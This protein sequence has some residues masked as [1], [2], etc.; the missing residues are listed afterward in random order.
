YPAIDAAH[1]GDVRELWCDVV[2][3][4]Q[5]CGIDVALCLL[6]IVLGGAQRRIDRGERR[7]IRT[8]AARLGEPAARAGEVLGTQGTASLIEQAC[9]IAAVRALRQRIIRGLLCE[10]RQV[11]ACAVRGRLQQLTAR[12]SLIEGGGELRELFG[13]RRATQ[14]LRLCAQRTNLRRLR[15]HIRGSPDPDVGLLGIPGGERAARFTLQSHDQLLRGLL[16]AG[17]AR[18]QRPCGLD[19]EAG[20]VLYRRDE[21]TARE[22][23]T[24]AAEV[25]GDARVELLLRELLTRLLDQR[26]AMLTAGGILER[27]ERSGHI[28]SGCGPLCLA[29]HR[30]LA[31]RADLRGEKRDTCV[32]GVDGARLVGELLGGVEVL[33]LQLALRRGEQAVDH[34]CESVDRAR[35]ACVAAQRLA[36]QLGRG[37]IPSRPPR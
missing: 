11:E 9:R 19:V 33:L 23:I 21:R 36:L 3:A 4:R 18:R 10:L 30:A 5:G 37:L 7:R 17:S 32:I 28:A 8:R 14:L 22:R 20:V 15:S 35:I 16:H 2:G 6:R 12:E 27:G 13:V 24:P 31:L 34:L 26:R 29:E 1:A 25:V